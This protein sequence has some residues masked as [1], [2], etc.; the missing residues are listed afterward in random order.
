MQDAQG[1]SHG[2][3][4]LTD[5]QRQLV[6][7]HID[8]ASKMASRYAPVFRSSREEMHNSALLSLCLAALK[9]DKSRG[10]FRKYASTTIYYNWSYTKDIGERRLKMRKSV[11]PPPGFHQF[12]DEWDSPKDS[13]DFDEIDFEIDTGMTVPFAAS[14]IDVSRGVRMS[15]MRQF[16]VSTGSLGA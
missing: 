6:E 8:L 3:D 4:V 11:T 1:V 2:G 16:G 9:Y 5:E 14:A 12:D 15:L 10:S 7:D 13:R